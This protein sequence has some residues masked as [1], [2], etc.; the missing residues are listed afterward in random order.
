VAT[1]TKKR[2]SADQRR[3]E[4]L[5]AAIVEF[6]RRGFHATTTAD[7]ASAAGVSQPYIYALFP[8]KRALFLACHERTTERIRDTL[9][10]AR[11]DAG[12]EADLEVELG[13]AYNQMVEARPEQILFQMQARAA[14]AADPE[15]RGPVRER[16]MQLVDESVRLHGEPRQVVLRYIAWAQLHDVAIALDLPEEYRP[17]PY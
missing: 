10:Q 9:E 7:I 14:A 5:E 15:I 12:P 4:L 13:R 16:W 3:E 17:E 11:Q 6:A 8:D 2:L 1:Q